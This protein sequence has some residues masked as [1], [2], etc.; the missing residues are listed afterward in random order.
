MNRARAALLKEAE[1]FSYFVRLSAMIHQLRFS[2][3]SGCA[4][5]H[6]IVIKSNS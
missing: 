1:I 6:Y 3:T 4:M 2:F 5:I